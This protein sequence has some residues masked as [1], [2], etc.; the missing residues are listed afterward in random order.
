[1][2]L[3]V[4]PL[5]FDGMLAGNWLHS[6][7]AKLAGHKSV[8][9]VLFIPYP[10]REGAEARENFFLAQPPI[11]TP[12]TTK[13]LASLETR[14]FV[15]IEFGGEGE[16]RTL[17]TI[18]CIHT[19][20]ACS[21]SHSDTSPLSRRANVVESFSDGKGFFQN[22]HALRRLCRSS[23][24]RRHAHHGDSAILGHSRR[25]SIVA[26]ATCRRPPAGGHGGK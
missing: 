26:A 15:Y 7:D 10:S 2:P 12:E 13:P 4:I 14:G 18:S 17:D 19:F 3:A 6:R 24:L 8:P 1:M 5:N 9:P 11:Q 23:P 20:Q 16:I 25:L 21:L 22:F